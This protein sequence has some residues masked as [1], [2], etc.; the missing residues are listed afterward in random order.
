M[1]PCSSRTCLMCMFALCLCLPVCHQ[2]NMF[3]DEGGYMNDMP[4]RSWGNQQ[5][6]NNKPGFAGERSHLIRLIAR[7]AGC[8][9]C[10]LLSLLHRWLSGWL[11]GLVGA[12]FGHLGHRC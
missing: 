12:D 5:R 7:V 10:Q 1:K 11:A 4:N 2:T 6:G 8:L 3:L 9:P